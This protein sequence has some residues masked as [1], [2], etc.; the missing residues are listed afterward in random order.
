MDLSKEPDRLR[1]GVL[2]ILVELFISWPYGVVCI[3]PAAAVREW[4]SLS[5]SLPSGDQTSTAH[6]GLLERVAPILAILSFSLAELGNVAEALRTVDA[7]F[8]KN[9]HARS[10]AR[11]SMH[12]RVGPSVG[13]WLMLPLGRKW[14]IQRLL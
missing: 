3:V 1:G 6:T 11:S 4:P 10:C 12:G 5:G 13:R 9:P 14:T 7:P 8:H 2:S